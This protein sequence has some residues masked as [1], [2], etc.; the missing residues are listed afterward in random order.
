MVS[1]NNQVNQKLLQ[2]FNLG[3]YFT[4]YKQWLLLLAN[5]RCLIKKAKVFF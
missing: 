5:M 4:R 1:Y 2:Y 3:E